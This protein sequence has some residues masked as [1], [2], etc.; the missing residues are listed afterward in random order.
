[1][2]ALLG[3]VSGSQVVGVVPVLGSSG[4]APDP[5]TIISQLQGGIHARVSQLQ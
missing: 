2:D 5:S 4:A 1:V 3:V